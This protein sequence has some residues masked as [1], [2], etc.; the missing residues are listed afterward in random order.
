MAI[1]AQVLPPATPVTLA[2][3]KQAAEHFQVTTMT[4]YRWSK[5]PGF[6]RPLKR[7]QVVLYNVAAIEVWLAGEA[8]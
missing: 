1:T 3:P 5:Q 4:L 6:P 7:G 8:A 2:R